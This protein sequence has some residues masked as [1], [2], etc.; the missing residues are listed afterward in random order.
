MV[1]AATQQSDPRPAAFD[2]EVDLDRDRRLV[3]SAQAGNKEAFDVLY[4]FYFTRLERYCLRRLHDPHEA[5]DIAQEAFL[6]AWRRC[7]LSEETAA[8]IPG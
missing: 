6:R 4:E 8:S 7:R 2:G 5:Q 3:Q 1:T